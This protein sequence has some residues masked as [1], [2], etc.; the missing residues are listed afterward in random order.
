MTTG[1]SAPPIGAVKRT[2]KIRVTPIKTNNAV[3]PEMPNNPVA[4][5]NSRISIIEINNRV[6]RTNL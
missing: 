6:D 4:R 5:I 3:W 1:I 2:P